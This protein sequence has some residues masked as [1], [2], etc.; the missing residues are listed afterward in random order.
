MKASAYRRPEMGGR[1][2]CSKCHCQ[3]LARLRTS[4]YV[5]VPRHLRVR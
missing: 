5:T 1:T 2:L 4:R 3:A